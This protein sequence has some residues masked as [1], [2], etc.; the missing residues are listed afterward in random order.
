MHR[1]L[2]R[3]ELLRALA[4]SP[5]LASPSGW[6]AAAS[7]SGRRLLLVE[8][9]GGNDGLNT[10]VPYADP[11]YSELR[12]RIGVARDQVL[13]INDALGLNPALEPLMPMFRD[14]EMAIVLGV[15]YD[16]PNRSHFRGIEIWDTAS[17][18]DEILHN[19]WLLKAATRLQSTGGYASTGAV[20]G[21]NAMPLSGQG[22]STVSFDS[23][24]QFLNRAAEVQSPREISGNSALAHVVQVQRGIRQAVE[25]LDTVAKVPG[26]PSTVI[27][28]RMAE[29]ANLL[30]EN[31]FAPVIKV[32]HGRFDTHVNQRGTQDRLLREFAQAMAALR[33]HLKASGHW[34]RTLVVT[35]SEFG[36][37]ARENGSQGTDHG[38]AAPH[39]VFGG[40]V[41]GGLYGEQPKLTGLSD[42]DMVH[43]VDF[44][45]YY[46]TVLQRWWGFRDLQLSPSSYPVLD[47]V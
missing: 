40:K 1:Q 15:G 23:S 16:R 17:R 6:A 33:K 5:L 47:F 27:G 34:D 11:A 31:A 12:P 28:R 41:K 9:Q 2:S 3:R 38:T 10:V 7:E 26:F 29:A 14:G 42:G 39:F 13:P 24:Q 20:I 44:R 30:G 37:R 32:S 18:S 35:Y 22:A 45:S 21:G 43:T 25:G 8:L 46:N 19:G 36:R 4:L